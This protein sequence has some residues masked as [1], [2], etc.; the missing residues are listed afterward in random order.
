MKLIRLYIGLRHE[1]GEF[2]VS[3]IEK[4]I[5]ST[6]L[7]TF[8]SLTLM[9]AEGWFRGTSEPCVIALVATDDLAS[10]LQAV[11]ELRCKLRQDGI[12]VEFESYYHR[13]TQGRDL[14]ALEHEILNP[15]SL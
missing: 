4:V 12:G 11:E 3:E 8:S 13:V 10:L 6:L 7:P 5:S 1:S 15:R 9:K 14:V 2:A